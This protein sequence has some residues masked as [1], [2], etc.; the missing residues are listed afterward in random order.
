MPEPTNSEVLKSFKAHSEE[1]HKFQDETR[2]ANGEMQ[3]F[4]AETEG[5]LAELHKKVEG[6]A[7]KED[8]VEL[9]EFMKSVNIGL[10]IF[11]FSWNNASKIGSLILLIG[12]IFVFFKVGIAGAVA[13]ILGK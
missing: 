4:K 13:Y 6:L 10:G 1:D 7:T 9:K 8:I 11:K 2:I 12:G 3:L 5:S